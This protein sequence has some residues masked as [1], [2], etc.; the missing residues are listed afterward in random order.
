[1]DPQMFVNN[2]FQNIRPQMNIVFESNKVGKH[3][4]RFYYGTTINQALITYLNKIGRPDLINN[5]SNKILFIFNA[6][7]I[8]FNDQTKI[9]DFFHNVSSPLIRADFVNMINK[10]YNKSNTFDPKNNTNNNLNTDLGIMPNPSF[11]FHQ[12]LE[13]NQYKNEISE[14]KKQLKEKDDEISELKKQLKEEHKR[15]EDNKK[16]LENDELRQNK[17]L[18]KN[19]LGPGEKILVIYFN[20]TGKQILEKPKYSCKNT[21]LFVRLEERF[22]KEFPEFKE[23]DLSFIVNGKRIKRFKTIEENQI[24]NNDTINIFANNY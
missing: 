4:I 24:R 6:K 14:L 7:L 3:N 10:S 23:Y 2:P 19:T 8:N 1:M 13:I 5:K 15:L 12:N 11:K 20:R 16:N 21:E 22:Y 9:E 17:I 18:L